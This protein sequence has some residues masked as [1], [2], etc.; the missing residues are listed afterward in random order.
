MG[1]RDRHPENT[2]GPWFV[3]R[4]CIDCDASRQLAPDLFG[5]ADSQA[6]VVRQPATDDEEHAAWLAALACPT[7]SIRTEPPQPRPRG[8]YP[9]ELADGVAYCGHN[10]PDSFGANAFLVRRPAGNLL[11]DAPRYTSELV[12][13]FEAA[14]GLD[15]VL[16]THRDDVADAERYADVFGARVWIH[17]ADHDAAPYA[18]DV[19]DGDDP[20]TVQPNVIAHPVPGHTRGSM[21][22]VVDDRFLFSG[23]SL[24]WHRRKQDLAIHR[25][26]TWYSLGTQLDSL[27]RLA[28]T[29][30]F[31]WV[32]A[33]HGDRHETT[34]DDMHRRLLALVARERARLG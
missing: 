4:A 30:R 8:L 28:H 18:T 26:Y 32:L 33:G 23:D 16:L 12:T 27:E 9:H 22:F 24:F 15:H 3:D 11:V 13:A 34:H 25:A 31:A 6:V 20:V 1:E 19:V 17:A 7:R 10:S 2:P 29:A 21:A 5:R 14:G